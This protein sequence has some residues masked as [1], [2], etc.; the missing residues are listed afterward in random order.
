MTRTT[1]TLLFAV[2]LLAPPAPADSDT[3]TGRQIMEWVDERD[4]GRIRALTG[5]FIE[6]ALPPGSAAR[7]EIVRVRLLTAERDET[8]AEVL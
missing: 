2:L 1:L 5:N 4:D 6:V 7:G 8:S 3:P